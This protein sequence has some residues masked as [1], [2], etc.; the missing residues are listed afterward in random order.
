MK[1]LF[2]N[3]PFNPNMERARNSNHI[4]PIGLAA[5]AAKAQFDGHDIDFFDAVSLTWP[6]IAEKLESGNWEMVAMTVYTQDIPVVTHLIPMIKSLQPKAIIL[7]GGTHFDEFN[8]RDFLRKVPDVD[9]AVMGE[10]EVAFSEITRH[11]D[12][13][14]DY[15]DVEH[16]VYR[17]KEGEIIQNGKGGAVG[18]DD[19]HSVPYHLLDLDLYTQAELKGVVNRERIDKFCA[20]RNLHDL[21]PFAVL[22]SKGCTSK[23]NFCGID[24]SLKYRTRKIADII[25]DVKELHYKYGY[26]AIRFIASNLGN[27]RKPVEELCDE[28][29]KL[30]F[31]ILWDADMKVV[32]MNER[33]VKKMGAAGC[34]AIFFGVESGSKTLQK[35]VTKVVPPKYLHETL[36]LCKE[37]GIEPILS[38]IT[39]LVGETRETYFETLRLIYELRQ[40]KPHL[41]S[42]AAMVYPRTELFTVQEAAGLIN[43]DRWFAPLEIPYFEGTIG[44][45]EAKRMQ[46]GIR[47]HHALLSQKLF[48]MLEGKSFKNVVVRTSSSLIEAVA[49]SEMFEVNYPYAKRTLIS[50]EPLPEK[51]KGNFNEEHV[52]ER[53]FQRADLSLI[54]VSGLWDL[55]KQWP[56]S[57]FIGKHF[58]VDFETNRI[59][60]G[61]SSIEFVK[62]TTERIIRAF[63]PIEIFIKS[64][65]RIRYYAR[66]L[67][68]S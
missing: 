57:L 64:N 56:A 21:V 66:M 35:R 16:I 36:R 10:G 33:L 3:P 52:G 63:E 38:F 49:A 40:Y 24:F 18:I 50:R 12:N 65:P 46:E 45:E 34:Y 7:C 43:N 32:G 11:C 53:L 55:V 28:L 29:M 42:N 60:R 22:F 48:P 68:S 62:F 23:C 39:G 31:K 20:E 67:K 54:I 59:W 1:I 9:I 51:F 19:V 25:K 6:K 30:P 26:H 14:E 4:V 27:D 2:I 8:S 5:I 15:C 44:V 47:V 58:Y 41:R 37:N 13:K 61:L 17:T